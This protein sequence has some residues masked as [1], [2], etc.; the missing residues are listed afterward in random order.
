LLRPNPALWVEVLAPAQTEPCEKAKLKRMRALDRLV[1]LKG[2]FGREA[3]AQ[4]AELLARLQRTR[5]RAPDALIRLH[6]TALFLRA[7]PQNPRVQRLA[8]EILDSFGPRLRGMD[9]SPF[10]NPEISGIAGTAVS[11]NFSYEVAKSL[12]ARHGRSIEI[13]W[14]NYARPDRLGPVLARLIPLAGEDSSVEP[15]VNWRRW[16]ESARGNIQWLIRNVDPQTY[17]LLEIPLCWNLGDS[18]ATRSRTRI[19]RRDIY[20]HKQPLLKRSGISLELEFSAPK[21]SVTKLTRTRAQRILDLIL[22]TSAVRY[23]E[24][25]GFTHPDPAHVYHADFGRGVDVFFFGVPETWRLPLRAYH[26]GMFFKNGVPIGYVES[27]SLFERMEAGFNLYY[28]FREGETAWL[29]ARM[30]KLFRERL[31]VTCYSIDPYQLGRDNEE[32]IESGAFWFYY[33]LGFRCGSE[34][35]ARL[36]AKEEHRIQTDP[37]YRSSA[38]TLRRLA[39]APLIYGGGHEWNRFEVRNL[40]N[41]KF[42][43]PGEIVRAKRA[44]EETRYL[45]LLQKDRKLRAVVLRLGSM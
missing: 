12:A 37:R 14:E 4:A 11:T 29:Y 27:L 24:L 33:K 13:D 19:P 21:I 17:D 18:E 40:R 6:E 10:E 43:L 15:H 38:A 25:Y 9:Q 3:A 23:R 41:K 44:A 16:F 31:G 45:R 35:T 36:A 5:L 39:Q 26:C 34:E 7:Y 1:R 20:Y 28:T 32:A 8:D 2:Q 42:K 22:D 30:L